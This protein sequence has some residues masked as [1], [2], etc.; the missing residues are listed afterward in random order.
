M[1]QKRQEKDRHVVSRVGLKAGEGKENRN[2]SFMSRDSHEGVT[3]KTVPVH[4]KETDDEITKTSAAFVSFCFLLF[5]RRL[6]VF[7]FSLS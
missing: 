2:S 6:I 7:V 4:D 3:M 1:A 5:W